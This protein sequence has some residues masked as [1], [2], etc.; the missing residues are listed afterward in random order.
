MGTRYDGDILH[1]AGYS[2]S[3][4]R[5]GREWAQICGARVRDALYNK[6]ARLFRDGRLRDEVLI[7]GNVGAQAYSN[8]FKRSIIASLKRG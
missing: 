4:S 7:Q 2:V 3:P 6:N 5:T 1:P 8:S